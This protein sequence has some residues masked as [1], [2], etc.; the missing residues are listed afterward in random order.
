MTAVANSSFN[1]PSNPYRNTLRNLR[2]KQT[3]ILELKNKPLEELDDA[4]LQKLKSL[5][6]VQEEIEEAEARYV[7]WEGILGCLPNDQPAAP[8]PAP[9]KKKK[10]KA[11]QE[12]QPLSD[13]PTAQRTQSP[14]AEA[15]PAASPE[16]ME[17]GPEEKREQPASPLAEHAA[18][19]ASSTRS[20]I[21]DAAT[22]PAHI[23]EPTPEQQPVKDLPGLSAA[24]LMCPREER[25]RRNRIKN[26]RSRLEGIQALRAK[27]PATLNDDQRAKIASQAKIE[28]ELKELIETLIAFGIEVPPAH[29]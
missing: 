4:Q 18:S 29:P 23:N 10:K 1:N 22:P 25:T 5:G 17:E 16:P 15:S 19:P 28:A 6:K 27:D 8:P 13:P 21:R 3:A 7:E 12:E 9:S 26:L 20:P 24:A 14:A 11:L 2:K